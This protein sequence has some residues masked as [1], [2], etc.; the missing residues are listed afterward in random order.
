MP[1]ERLDP[2]L[3]LRRLE[4]RSGPLLA[5]EAELTARYRIYA[6]KKTCIARSTS[7]T[8]RTGVKKEVSALRAANMTCFL[9]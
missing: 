8:S 4:L 5:W 1:Q 3:W 6:K 9:P 2:P 7:K